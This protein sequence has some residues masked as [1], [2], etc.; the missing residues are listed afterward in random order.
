MHSLNSHLLRHRETSTDG[1]NNLCTIIH[2]LHD[3][4]LYVGQV[5]QGKRLLG[6]FQLRCDKNNPATQANID[7]SQFDAVL[8]ASK[9][10]CEKS[11]ASEFS[12]GRDGYAIFHATGHHEGLYVT[13][14]RLA[15]QKSK[16]TFDSR[17]LNAG[18]L[19]AIRLLVPGE[20][21]LSN[22]LSRQKMPL[23][24]RQAADGKYPALTKM[25]PVTVS[26]TEKSFDPPRTETWPVQVVIVRPEVP[27]VLKLTALKGDAKPPAA[28]KAK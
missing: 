28:R 5:V 11:D 4:G 14:T 8:G 7:L 25:T 13:L 15:E 2:Q 6:T 9:K 24:V 3:E 1:F 26:L 23:R 10:H 12:V 20:Y 19:V 17:T 18:D 22:E 16:P 27:C 21:V